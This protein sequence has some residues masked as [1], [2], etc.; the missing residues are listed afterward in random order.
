MKNNIKKF[1]I[2]N[3][4]FISFVYDSQGRERFNTLKEVFNLDN[5]IYDCKSIPDLKILDIPLNIDQ[6]LLRQ[7]KRQSIDFLIKNLVK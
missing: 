1:I 3:K 2:F 5:R 6:N 7:L 4:P